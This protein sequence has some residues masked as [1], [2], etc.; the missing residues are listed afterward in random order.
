MAH[1]IQQRFSG[2]DRADAWRQAIQWYTA[3]QAELGL[4]RDQFVDHCVCIGRGTTVVYTSRCLTQPPHA[5]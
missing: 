1:I 2:R 5:A 3:H 4:S